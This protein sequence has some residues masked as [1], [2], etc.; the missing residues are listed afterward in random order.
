MGKRLEKYYDFIEEQMGREGKIEL[1]KLTTI[2]SVVAPSLP[3]SE[4]NIQKFRQ[5]IEKIIGIEAPFF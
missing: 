3:D 4:E 5:A 1:A 2:P